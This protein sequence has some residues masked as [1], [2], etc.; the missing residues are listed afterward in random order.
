MNE[1]MLQGHLTT[2]ALRVAVESIQIRDFGAAL[3]YTSARWRL[4]AAG[5][6]EHMVRMHF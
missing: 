6:H 3:W 5:Q 2:V 4:L 1:L